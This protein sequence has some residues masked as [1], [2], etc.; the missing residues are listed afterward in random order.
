MIF[1]SIHHDVPYELNM[2]KLDYNTISPPSKSN[3]LLKRIKSHRHKNA[4]INAPLA[5]LNRISLR[6]HARTSSLEMSVRR[7]ATSVV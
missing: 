2:D 3:S 5:T 4:I 6:G 1:I 7:G